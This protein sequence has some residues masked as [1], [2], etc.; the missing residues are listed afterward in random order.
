MTTRHEDAEVQ[1]SVS[2][3]FLPSESAGDINWFAY[4]ITIH[5]HGN[6]AVRLLSRYWH[7]MDADDHVREV[8]GDGVVGQQP[9][10][11][12]D[13]HY[14]YTSF[15]DFSTAV[16]FMKGHYTMETADGRQ[17][18]AAIAVFTLALPGALH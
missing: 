15:V 2:P 6:V 17:F 7:I 16:G 4:R 8:S 14:E 10:I 3:S 5:N 18:N 13:G 11:E 12:V 9:V 1:I